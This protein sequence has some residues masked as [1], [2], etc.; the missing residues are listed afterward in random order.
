MNGSVTAPSP[1]LGPDM[2]ILLVDDDPNWAELLMTALESAGYQVRVAANADEALAAVATGR[3]ALAVL[4]V[5]MPG[6][7]G[8]ELGTILREEFG[9][10]FMIMSADNADASVKEATSVG[11]I[12]YLLKSGDPGQCIPTVRAALARAEE[13]RRLRERSAARNGAATRARDQHRGRA[14]DGTPATRPQRCLRSAA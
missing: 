10:P 12:A 3:P 14:P 7:S 4:D 1:A 9:V 2:G 8:I 13:F 6:I 5:R 11:A